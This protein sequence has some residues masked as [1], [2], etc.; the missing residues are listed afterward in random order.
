M[1]KF[2]ARSFLALALLLGATTAHA[3]PFSIDLSAVGAGYTNNGSSSIDVDL[4][5]LIGTVTTNYATINQSF[6]ADG[7][8]N[9]G[10]TFTEFGFLNAVSIDGLDPVAIK[11]GANLTHR[12]Y[13]EFVDLAG[14]ISNYSAGAVTP[15]DTDIYNLGNAADD[16][17][18][19]T[20][21]PG[22]GQIKLYLDDDFDSGNGVDATLATFEVLSG[23]GDSPKLEITAVPEGNFALNMDFDSYLAG[24]WSLPDAGMTFEAWEAL[25][26]DSITMHTQ[27]LDA[28]VKTPL[29]AYG[30]DGVDLATSADK[31]NDGFTVGVLNQGSV[32][33]SAVPEPATM[34]LFGI[35]LLGLANVSRKRKN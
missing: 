14:S 12:M 1:K 26:P 34:L 4:N 5:L 11:D 27:N 23:S 17:Y 6:G 22:A 20:F 7:I 31:T 30:T 19:L 25:Y 21:T 24:I 15:G 13:F 9:N 10:D 8:F 3:V 35:G 2:L 32:F 33:V 29:T 16:T 18:D 28:T